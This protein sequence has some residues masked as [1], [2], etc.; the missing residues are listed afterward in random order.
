[1][2]LAI[3]ATRTVSVNVAF[4]A[5]A[6][7]AALQVIVPLAPTAGVVQL[8]PAGTTIDWKR[9]EAGSVSVTTTVDAASGPALCAV[10]V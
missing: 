5:F 7:V 8:K 2:P 6:I 9:S 10:S 3:P 1:M 4:A